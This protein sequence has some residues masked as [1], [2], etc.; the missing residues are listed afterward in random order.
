MRRLNGCVGSENTILGIEWGSWHAGS[1]AGVVSACHDLA[2]EVI[3]TDGSSYT[4]HTVVFYFFWVL[5]KNQTA[6]LPGN[7]VFQC[8][9]GSASGCAYHGK[10]TD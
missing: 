7:V 2:P 1:S 8:E 3:G 6:L 5:L 4:K 9:L 10:G